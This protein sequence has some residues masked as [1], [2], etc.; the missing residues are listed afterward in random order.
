MSKNMKIDIRYLAGLVDADGYIYS[1]RPSPTL[2][3]TNT[4]KDLIDALKRTFGG[5][6]VKSPGRKPGYRTYWYWR[7]C[8]DK[9]RKLTNRIYPYLIV[10][11]AQAERIF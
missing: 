6:A 1:K 2:G 9:A 4:N 7:V 5:H 8:G 3:V 10:K 11:Q